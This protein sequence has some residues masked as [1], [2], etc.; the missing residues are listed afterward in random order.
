MDSRSCAD[1]LRVLS[2]LL[3]RIR[4]CFEFVCLLHKQRDQLVFFCSF[5]FNDFQRD[6]ISLAVR[7]GSFYARLSPPRLPVQSPPSGFPTVSAALKSADP[8]PRS[9]LYASIPSS[10]LT[11]SSRPVRYSSCTALG[12]S[13]HS[14]PRCVSRFPPS[15][16]SPIALPTPA[17][18]GPPPSST[19]PS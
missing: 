6:F 3:E 16:R 12:T 1:W 17:T 8:P 13:Q 15:S 14:V 19:F 9:I 11:L 7:R 2:C 4:D 10:S 5:L 18:V